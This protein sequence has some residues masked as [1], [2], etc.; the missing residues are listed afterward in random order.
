MA[1]PR[2]VQKDEIVLRCSKRTYLARTADRSIVRMLDCSDCRRRGKV[3][4]NLREEEAVM[5]QWITA[6]AA[7]LM[8]VGVNSAQA[9]EVSSAP[10]TVVVTIV[11][12][13]AT[14]FT[15]GKD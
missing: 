3:A 4:K 7:A 6:I 9:Q 15:E 13:G 14:F 5:K 12:G 2:L 1:D 10:G 8:F 11:P